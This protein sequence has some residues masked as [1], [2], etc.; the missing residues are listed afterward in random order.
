MIRDEELELDL[1]HDL[2]DRYEDSDEYLY[3]FEPCC[4]NCR[5]FRRDRWIAICKLDEFN[6]PSYNGHDCCED[7]ER[8]NE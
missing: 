1:R 8:K 7:W 6:C 2:F 5:Y 4:N 3:A